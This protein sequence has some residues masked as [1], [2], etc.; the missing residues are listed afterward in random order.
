[1]TASSEPCPLT[2]WIIEESVYVKH[3]TVEELL[4]FEQRREAY[5]RDYARF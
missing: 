3:L 1:M 5:R 2:R 4:F